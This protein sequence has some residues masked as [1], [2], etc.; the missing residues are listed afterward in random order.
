[1]TDGIDEAAQQRAARL[2]GAMY[3]IQMATGVF[4]QIY[5]RGSLIVRGDPTQTARNIIDS[6]GLFR[7][8]I[9]SDL[10]TY[11][12]VLIAT[13]ALYVLLR[14]V[15]RNLA[16]LAVLFRLM[17][18]AIHFNATVDSLG[19]LR[20]LSGAPYLKSIDAGQLHSMAQLALSAQGEAVNMGFIL[21]GL[22]SAVFAFLLFKSRFIP[23]LLSGWGVFASLLIGAYALSIIVFPKA[24][25]L[26]VLPMLPMGIYEV[27]LGFWLLLKGAKIEPSGTRSA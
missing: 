8:G 18:L 23:R 11:T 12:A 24:G 20:L 13:W 21:L 10:A 15:N 22:G 9:A 16:M 2:A 6:E 14:S 5:A 25:A 26:Q 7:F 4:T 17:E 19:V 3:L 27:S 1:M